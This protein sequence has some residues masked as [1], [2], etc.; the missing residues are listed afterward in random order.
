[1]LAVGSRTQMPRFARDPIPAQ[2]AF[3]GGCTPLRFDICS[4]N[5]D[6]CYRSSYNGHLKS[7]ND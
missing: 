1:M 3:I 5:R 4:G 2:I 6:T 7:M